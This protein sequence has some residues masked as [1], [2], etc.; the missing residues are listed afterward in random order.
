M[1]HK[2]DGGLPPSRPADLAT[3]GPAQRAGEWTQRRLATNQRVLVAAPA[4]L[5]RRGVPRSLDELS[6][7]DCLVVRENTDGGPMRN[8]HWALQREAG[9]DAVTVG[10]IWNDPSRT[11]NLYVSDGRNCGEGSECQSVGRIA[12]ECRQ[13]R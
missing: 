7:H 9:L 11:G 4:Y 6:Q 2:I 5:R 12:F 8:D 13:S 3:T 10:D 1:T